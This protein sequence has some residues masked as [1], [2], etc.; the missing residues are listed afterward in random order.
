MYT[1]SWVLITTKP[2]AMDLET[3]HS[4]FVHSLNMEEWVEGLLAPRRVSRVRARRTPCTSNDMQ[5][6]TVNVAHDLLLA[7]KRTDE[8]TDAVHSH[9]LEG[10]HDDDSNG[11]GPWTR[12]TDRLALRAYEQF[13]HL[14]PRQ[15]NVVTV[16]ASVCVLLHTPKKEPNAPRPSVHT[17]V[18]GCRIVGS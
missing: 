5:N 7:R 9:T 2:R 17:H 3:A 6:H 1:V 11:L 14:V 4:D 15:V 10:R 13:L 8:S 18:H 12:F 16:S